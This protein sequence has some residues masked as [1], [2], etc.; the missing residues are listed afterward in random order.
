MKISYISNSMPATP[1]KPLFKG[2]IKNEDRP[3]FKA[4]ELFKAVD[5]RN[6]EIDKFEKR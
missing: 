5:N 4:C 1:I 3:L 2:N 6:L